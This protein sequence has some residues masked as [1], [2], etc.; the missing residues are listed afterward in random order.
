ME[1]VKRETNREEGGKK[2]KKTWGIEHFS[3]DIENIRMKGNSGLHGHYFFAG[4]RER[5]IFTL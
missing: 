3:E 5:G 1:T 4:S 2:K